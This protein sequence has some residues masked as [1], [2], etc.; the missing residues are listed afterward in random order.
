M[1]L[2]SCCFKKYKLISYK[3]ILPTSDPFSTLIINSIRIQRYKKAPL[4]PTSLTQGGSGST[5]VVIQIP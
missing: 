3:L 4:T 1:E 2:I 5:I